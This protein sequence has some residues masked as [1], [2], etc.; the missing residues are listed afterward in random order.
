MGASLPKKLGLLLAEPN[1][2]KGHLFKCASS[3]KTLEHR[4]WEIC[5]IELFPPGNRYHLKDL[6]AKDSTYFSYMLSVL[7]VYEKVTGLGA[8]VVKVRPFCTCTLAHR[9]LTGP[10]VPLEQCL[11][12]AASCKTIG[13]LES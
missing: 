7:G 1:A 5:F 9:G 11:F 12:T 13:P 8:A 3:Q 6:F 4:G 2:N 10:V